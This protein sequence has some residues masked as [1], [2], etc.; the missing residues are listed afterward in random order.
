MRCWPRSMP[1]R[2]RKIGPNSWRT[3]ATRVILAP[4]LATRCTAV[5]APG[6][7]GIAPSRPKPAS[8]AFRPGP[9]RR[10]SRWRSQTIDAPGENPLRYQMPRRVPH[11]PQKE[12]PALPHPRNPGPN[13]VIDGCTNVPDLFPRSCAAHDVCYQTPSVPRAQC[14]REL[15]ENS[16]VERPDLFEGQILESAARGEVLQP[17]VTY[18]WGV[19]LFGWLFRKTR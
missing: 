5:S 3:C 1:K 9:H 7:P 6:L 4:M 15:Y 18:Y 17:S 16:I 8:R 19:R 12:E 13:N 14:D 2:L 10:L 11:L